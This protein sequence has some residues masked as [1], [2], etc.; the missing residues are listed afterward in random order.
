MSTPRPPVR[1]IEFR[2]GAGAGDD[3][4]TVEL[5]DLDGG[6]AD[7]TAGGVDEHRLIEAKSGA[8]DDHVDCG[9]EAEGDRGGLFE[10][11]V[12]R[13]AE[14]VGGG[15]GNQLRHA[16]VAALADEV[17]ARA[18]VVVAVE[19]GFA[20]AATHAGMEH[21]FVADGD[22][23][24]AGAERLDDAGDVRAEDAR[25]AV[26]WAGHLRGPCLQVVEGDRADAHEDLA[27]AG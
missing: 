27:G 19:A 20:G 21:H 25:L 7:A 24:H 11:E 14:D 6:D 1:L 26:G 9:R 2:V 13:F 15:D 4:R 5:R 22:G 18:G 3:A 12:W 23:R 17:V 16:A 8:R 10:R